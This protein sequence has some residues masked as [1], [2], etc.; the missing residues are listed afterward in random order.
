MITTHAIPVQQ[1]D[2]AVKEKGDRIISIDVLRGLVMIVMALDH[3]RDY[4]H[5]PA[6]IYDP[7][8][9]DHT[10][11]PIFLTRWITHFCAPIFVFLAGTSANLTESRKGK[12]GLSVFLFTR[13]VW[14]IILE[15]TVVSFGWSFMQMFSVIFLQTIWALGISMIALSALIYLPTRLL[16][17]IAL[18]I[19]F[20]HNALDSIH[21]QGEDMKAMSWS[22][23]HDPKLFSFGDFRLMVAYPVLSWIGVMSAGYCFGE[24][25]TRFK[26]DKRKKILTM[27]GLACIALFV[28]LR[29][30]NMYGDRSLWETQKNTAFTILSFINTTKYPPSLLYILMTLGPA[31][32]FLAL[33][34]KPLNKLTNVISTYGRVPMF[35]YILHIYFIHVAFVVIGIIQG[36]KASALLDMNILNPIPGFGFR[37]WIVYIIW[38]LLVALLYPLC[39]RYDLYKRSNKE[40]LWL[41][42]L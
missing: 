7:L 14:L 22:F 16:L 26:G 10:S 34:E 8:D 21:V 39:K 33:A 30:T 13:G 24:I 6:I 31:M 4:F 5:A 17:A 3:V 11:V 12:K 25:F 42:Y 2:T 35:Y 37:L 29:F 40:K 23:V 28:I 27:M 1:A 36:Y 20:G 38:I 41:S 32:L 9:F 15:I 18:V 19:I